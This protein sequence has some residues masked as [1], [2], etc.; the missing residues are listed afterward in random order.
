MPSNAAWQFTLKIDRAFVRELMTHHD[1]RVIVRTI[2]ALANTLGMTTV[3]E[4]VEEPAQLEV[5]RLAGCSEI[6][7]YLVA[8]PMAI[9]RLLPLLEHWDE[10]NRPEPGAMPET[11]HMPL[12]AELPIR[13][14]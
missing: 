14:H 8:R 13:R 4:G 9:E 1:A 3:A 5:L 6:Q 7:G 10:D 2:V 11:Q 12:L